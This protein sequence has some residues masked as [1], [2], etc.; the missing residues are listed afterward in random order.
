MTKLTR[1][2]ML[3]LLDYERES[4]SAMIDYLTFTFG[5]ETVYSWFL[6]LQ[7]KQ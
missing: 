6:C 2:Q 4:D 3:D 5:I 1:K 7:D